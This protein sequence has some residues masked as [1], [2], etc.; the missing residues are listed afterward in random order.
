MGTTL[1]P[2]GTTLPESFQKGALRFTRR[3]KWKRSSSNIRL[4]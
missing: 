4:T 1:L 3:D 2:F